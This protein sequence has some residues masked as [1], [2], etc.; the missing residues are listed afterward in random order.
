MVSRRQSANIQK[1]AL[2][3]GTYG[4]FV[5]NKGGWN[6]KWDKQ[7]KIVIPKPFKGHLNERNRATRAKKIDDALKT[8][9]EKMRKYEQ[10]VESRKP[11]KD[12]QFVFDR[13]TKLVRGF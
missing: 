7:R 5:P 1:K 12:L 9:G 4:T 13:V 11:K 2:T 8:T 6:P 3:E 10:E